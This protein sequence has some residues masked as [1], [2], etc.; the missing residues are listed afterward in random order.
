M[1]ENNNRNAR[2]SVRK[3]EADLMELMSL[4]GVFKSENQARSNLFTFWDKCGAMVTSLLQFLKAEITGTWKMHLSSIAAMLHHYFAMDRQ[5]YARFLP[6]Y[7]TDM[8]QLELTHP[9]VYNELD[10]GNHSISRST[11]PFSQVSADMALEQSINVNSKS[12]GGVIGI[13]QSLPALKRWLLTIHEQASITSALKTMY[14]LQGGKQASH[15]E[16]TPRRV[17]CDKEDLQKMMGCFS[18]GLMTDPS[19]HNSNALLDIAT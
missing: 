15:K 18:S 1:V 5:N 11:Q 6:V 13:L 3:I 17:K 14:G 4:F 2:N 7:L 8:Q 9:G 16:A 19:T 10:A 12:R